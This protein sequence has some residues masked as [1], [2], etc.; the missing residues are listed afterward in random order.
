M[1]LRF[2]CIRLLFPDSKKRQSHQ[3]SL[4][5][6]FSGITAFSEIVHSVILPAP[7]SDSYMSLRF[8]LDMHIQ[9]QC[10]S[11]GSMSKY[12]GQ[13]LG[14]EAMLHPAT[15]KLMPESMDFNGGNSTGFQQCCISALDYP[16]LHA[17][18]SSR[19]NICGAIFTKT[20]RIKQQLAWQWN[21]PVGMFCLRRTDIQNGFG[22]FPVSGLAV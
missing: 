8:C 16:R 11:H 22:N 17:S 13:G 14:I 3:R 1:E 21:F 12:F 7:S 5:R 9:I 15:G 18:G 6:E 4:T 19:Q 20:F 2:F 10:G